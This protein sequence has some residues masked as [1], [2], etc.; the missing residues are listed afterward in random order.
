MERTEPN[1]VVFVFLSVKFKLCSSNS[2]PWSSNP[3]PEESWSDRH[4][5]QR[6]RGDVTLTLVPIATTF[7]C[8]AIG[9]HSNTAPLSS[10]CFSNDILQKVNCSLG[11]VTEKFAEQLGFPFFGH[12]DNSRSTTTRPLT[13]IIVTLPT[14]RVL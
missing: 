4:I 14:A 7:A 5:R 9:L 1:K 3:V 2:P 6:N 11:K 12:V 13:F 10:I 8:C